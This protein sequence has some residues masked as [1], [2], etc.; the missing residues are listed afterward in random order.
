MPSTDNAKS[1]ANASGVSSW[2]VA[3]SRR[4]PSP[5]LE[6]MNSPITAPMTA[7]VIATLAPVT[8]KGS[9]AGS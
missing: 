4:K 5:S 2:E 6:P 1:A 3:L 9:A 8:M 7:S